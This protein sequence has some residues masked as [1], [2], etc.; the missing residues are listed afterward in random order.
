MPEAW[1]IISV[2]SVTVIMSIDLLLN[3]LYFYSSAAAAVFT[4]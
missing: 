3:V 1:S 4:L 2:V